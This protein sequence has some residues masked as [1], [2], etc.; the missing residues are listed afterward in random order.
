MELQVPPEQA[1]MTDP[2]HV[3]AHHLT[4]TSLD[5]YAES[6]GLL[7]PVSSMSLSPCSCALSA[8]T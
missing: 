3:S 6:P 8:E 5:L 7:Q 1:S 2:G 4:L